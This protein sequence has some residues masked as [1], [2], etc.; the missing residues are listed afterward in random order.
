MA[1]EQVLHLAAAIDEQRVRIALEKLG[2][3]F[4]F[5]MLHAREVLER[6]RII[7]RI[8]LTAC[9]RLGTLRLVRDAHGGADLMFGLRAPNRRP[10]DGRETNTAKETCTRARFRR[11][12]NGLF[13]PLT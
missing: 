8:G 13:S 5:Q 9:A 6:P 4:G 3:G 12:L 2:G 7:R 11:A 10:P 1:H